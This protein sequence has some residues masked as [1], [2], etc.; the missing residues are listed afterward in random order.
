MPEHRTAASQPPCPI[1]WEDV[2]TILLDMDG[3]LLDLRFDNFFWEEYIPRCYGK[4]NGLAPEAARRE[5][6]RRY[7]RS[8][9]TMD[10]YSPEHWSKELGLDVVKLEQQ[11]LKQ[12]RQLRLQ[13]DAQAFLRSLRQGGHAAILVTNANPAG[14]ASKLERTNLGALLDDVISSHAFRQP[15]EQPAFWTQLQARHPFNPKHTLLID[16]SEAVLEAAEAHGIRHLRTVLQP[17][18]SRPPRHGLRFPALRRLREA[19]PP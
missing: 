11:Q 6:R 9:G 5:V 17:D 16:D 4:A 7:A 3:V 14:L 8:Q 19:A 15:K 10:W 12:S 1:P 18:S 13:P 2:E